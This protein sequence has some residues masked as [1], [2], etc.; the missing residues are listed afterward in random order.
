VPSAWPLQVSR[1]LSGRWKK[2]SP[3]LILLG[4]RGSD[5]RSKATPFGCQRKTSLTNT[6]RSSEANRRHHVSC[7]ARRATSTSDCQCLCGMATCVLTPVRQGLS[8]P[9]APGGVLHLPEPAPMALHV[10][11]CLS[12]TCRQALEPLR[13][14]CEPQPV[15]GA[16]ADEQVLMCVV[17]TIWNG[18]DRTSRL[19]RHRSQTIIACQCAEIQA[20]LTP[21]RSDSANSAEPPQ[22]TRVTTSGM[23]VTGAR[24][25]R[26][27]LDW[28]P[29][30]YSISTLMA[31]QLL[32]PH[33]HTMRF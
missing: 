9:A 2:S 21:Q 24:G 20:W 8:E 31:Q 25:K 30:L 14:G 26:R 15:H 22:V 19:T 32:A 1:P 12:N 6:R 29:S 11:R 27:A 17:A 23:E 28:W 18:G 16:R 13:R 3:N 10:P 5:A 33:N 4:S 7:C